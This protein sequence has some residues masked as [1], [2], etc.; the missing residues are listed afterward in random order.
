[1][2]KVFRKN[3]V[4][5]FT[6]ILPCIIVFSYAFELRHLA[7]SRLHNTFE[8]YV[9]YAN[10]TDMAAYMRNA[11]GF[12]RGSWPPPVFYR[13]PLY[14]V[15][16][17][18]VHMFSSDVFSIVLTQIVLFL[19]T[20]LI[21]FNVA[22]SLFDERV[23]VLSVSLLTLCGG[24]VYWVAVPHSTVLE[25]FLAVLSFLALHRCR[26]EFNYVNI[27]AAGVAGAFLCLIRPNFLLVVPPA[28]FMICLERYFAERKLRR[29]LAGLCLGAICFTAPL[30]PLCVWNN[31][32]SDRFI[33]FTNN[34]W[35]TFRNSN[36]YDSCVYNFIYP[37]K[38]VMPLSSVAFWKHQ[39]RKFA[40]YW[41]SVEYPQ[42]VNFY[43]YKSK[44]KVLCS[45]P[46]NF[47][48]ISAL[49]IAATLLFF[50]D[51]RKHWLWLW[52][53][54]GYV[55]TIV[56][57]FII[58]R[59]RI[60]VVPVMAIAG[61]A[62]IMKAFQFLKI[63]RKAPGKISLAL[64]LRY[65]ACVTSFIAVF[66]F[67]N[68]FGSYINDTNWINTSNHCLNEL[69]L[70]GYAD[71]L[72]HSVSIHPYA[73]FSLNI[74]AADALSG[75]FDTATRSLNGMLAKH[76][77]YGYLL[78][79]KREIELLQRI[80]DGKLPLWVWKEH[81][82]REAAQGH[83]ANLYRALS[84]CLKKRESFGFS[85]KRIGYFPAEFYRRCESDASPNDN[86]TT[87]HSGGDAI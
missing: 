24:F 86:G 41:T 59:F 84:K 35:S 17:I 10:G 54:W 87:L 66:A 44:S 70:D 69:D 42:N 68:P 58:G 48:I 37:K 76:P 5:L 20:L 15:C 14:T 71:A 65:T 23:A 13:A 4:L 32:H 52:F 26:R 43:I 46:V 3:K 72:R 34:G 36:S 78:M 83:V 81:I 18:F 74:I 40:G 8:S 21:T 61:S 51:L 30:I 85:V 9:Y 53:V 38:P 29:S 28:I 2:K 6:L 39:F 7:F 45:L 62:C 12:L 80:S 22:K 64:K 1:M 77:G 33:L 56:A 60:P 57:F 55:L 47:G 19:G 50:S 79:T 73:L 49:F 31:L 16:L 11:L 67:S 63:L 25:T 27:C 75:R 82:E